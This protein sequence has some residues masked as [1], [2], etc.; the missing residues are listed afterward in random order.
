MLDVKEAVKIRLVAPPSTAI[1]RVFS[2]E[3]SRV[4]MLP[5]Q[6][7]GWKGVGNLLNLFGNCL[8]ANISESKFWK[9]GM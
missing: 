5:A 6:P 8:L 1:W 9:L 7:A 3:C 4:E 2:V